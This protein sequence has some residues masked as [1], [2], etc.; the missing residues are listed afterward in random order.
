MSL[1]LDDEGNGS[2]FEI[3]DD[4]SVPALGGV[5]VALRRGGHHQVPVAQRRLDDAVPKFQLLPSVVRHVAQRD[6]LPS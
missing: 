2:V 4:G 1:G 3:K 6:R 5:D